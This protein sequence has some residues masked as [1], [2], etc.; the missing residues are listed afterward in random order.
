M[1]Q[2]DIECKEFVEC[3]IN[4]GGVLEVCHK[5]MGLLESFFIE[6][7]FAVIFDVLPYFISFHTRVVHLQKMCEDDL[8]RVFYVQ[9]QL[10]NTA[11]HFW[12]DRE[13][14]IFWL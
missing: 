12:F 9:C 10:H 8:E 13:L 4:S 1:K 7:L 6:S 3:K 11:M 14:R 2:E 5:D